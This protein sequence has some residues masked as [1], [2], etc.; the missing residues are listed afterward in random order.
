MKERAK[1]VIHIYKSYVLFQLTASH[2]LKK[3]YILKC[4]ISEINMLSLV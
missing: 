3:L 1:Y 2:H 4:D